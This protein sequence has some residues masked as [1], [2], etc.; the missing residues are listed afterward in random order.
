WLTR[1]TERHTNWQ[2]LPVEASATEMREAP[3]LYVASDKPLLLRESDRQR[4]KTYIDQGGLLLA[5]NEGMTKEFADSIVTLAKQLYPA[6]EFRNLPTDHLI[7]SENFP[8][9]GLATTP[10]ALS[11]G[12][13]ELMVLLPSGD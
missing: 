5:V 8:V 2:I 6:Y 3:I 11:N 1:Q 10:R 4:I 12:V 9:K 7:Y 13:R